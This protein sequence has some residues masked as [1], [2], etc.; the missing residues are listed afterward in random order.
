MAQ[1]LSNI[2]I[3]AAIKFGKHQVGSETAESIVWV[4]AA[5]NHS[6]YPSNSVTLVAQKIIDFRAYDAAETGATWGNN[7]YALSNIHQWLNSSA[8]A[9]KWYTATH[10]N[11][12]PP[13][14]STTQNGTGYQ[15]R[16]GFLYNFTIGERNL[17]LPTTLTVQTGSNVSNKI[18]ANVFLPSLWEILGVGNTSDG[19]SCFEYFLPQNG[20]CVATTQARTN[21]SSSKKPPDGT[22]WDY[23]T[24]STLVSEPCKITNSG[25]SE[26]EYANQGTCGVRPVLNLPATAKISDAPDASGCYT[27]TVNNAPTISGS[28]S[29]LGNKTDDFTTT[30]T[31]ADG[32]SESVTV[33]EYIDNV[34]IRSY[35][36]TLGST[37]T[38]VVNG[39]TWLKLA[40]GIHTLKIVATD[41]FDTT[42]RTYTFTKVANKL[43]VKRKTAIESGTKPSRIIVTLVKN[44]PS[45]AT[46]KV[47][48]CN[49]GFD[50]SP[51]WETIPSSSITSGVPYDF[52]NTTKTASKWGVNI[53]V[54]VDRNGAEGACYIT[55]IGGNFE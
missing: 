1:L 24:R 54:T 46:L 35:V 4:V 32:D 23:W 45:T 47:E 27:C 17:I 41:G 49:N 2:P 18:I 19:S 48:V 43:I 50:A 29:D 22:A 7:N 38:F 36:A 33:T 9:G 12:A 30:Y 16:A 52:T 26:Y 21:T 55:E 40:N 28:N 10:A 44:I 5:K 15:D 11:D 39:V 13:N 42:T 53:R 6:G 31:I 3:G 20:R 34:A 37:N 51:K 14:S 25:D 8:S